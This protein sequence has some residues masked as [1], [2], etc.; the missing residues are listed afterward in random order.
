M[1]QPCYGSSLW[2]GDLDRIRRAQRVVL[3]SLGPVNAI[4]LGTGDRPYL[5]VHGMGGSRWHWVEQVD[6]L[7]RA[8]RV[9]AV[10]LPGFGGSRSAAWRRGTTMSTVLGEVVRALDLVDVTAVGH[11]MGGLIV[12]D[13][14]L[15]EPARVPRLALV[16]A[17]LETVFELASPHARMA[18]LRRRPQVAAA[19]LAELGSL[20]APLPSWLSEAVVKHDWL[21]KVA[22]APYFARPELIADAVV[23]AV[24]AEPA[25]RAI[26]P[27]ARAFAA[28]AVT[29][30]RVAG[31]TDLGVATLIISGSA[32]RL[33]PADDVTAFAARLREARLEI[34]VGAGHMPMIEFPAAVNRLLLDHG[35]H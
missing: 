3:T 24:L 29:A 8:T 33:I 25:A 31:L 15:A 22:L 35:G 21:R 14:A 10:D 20:S 12:C 7:S 26:L 17:T 34:V 6:E 30:R 16:S 11:S 1:Q 5:L 13:L 2:T 4:D 9:V 19:L 28:D 23:R 32:D 18:A 27:T